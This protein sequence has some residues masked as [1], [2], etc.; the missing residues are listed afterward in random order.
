MASGVGLNPKCLEVYQELKTRKKFKYII[1]TLNETNTEIIVDK[2]G[3]ESDY[4]S[5]VEKLPPNECRYAVYDFEYEKEGGKRNKI[6]FYSWAPGDAKIKSRMVFASS[7]D[8][9]RRALVGVGAEIQGT[10]SD[11]VSHESVLDRVS[12]S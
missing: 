5:F 2:T 12:R 3:E 6:T 9:L 1:Y 10:D 11:E 8:A 7:K 4:E